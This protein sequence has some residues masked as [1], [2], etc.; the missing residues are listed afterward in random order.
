MKEVEARELPEV[1][2]GVEPRKEKMWE[3]FEP[4]PRQLQ[5]PVVPVVLQE[6]VA[7]AEGVVEA[8]SHLQGEVE[9]EAEGIHRQEVEGVVPPQVAAVARGTIRQLLQVGF[10]RERLGSSRRQR[11]LG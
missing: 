2:F 8:G 9:E 5:A 3:R 11:M 4:G 7:R 10:R 6:L 1:A